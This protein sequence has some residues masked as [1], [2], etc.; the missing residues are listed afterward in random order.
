MVTYSN[1]RPFDDIKWKAPMYLRAQTGDF[2]PQPDVWLVWLYWRLEDRHSMER[3]AIAK[4]SDAVRGQDTPVQLTSVTKYCKQNYDGF[5]RGMG[6]GDLV[7][8][9]KKGEDNFWRVK[10]HTGQVM[11][12]SGWTVSSHNLATSKV[13]W[14]LFRDEEDYVIVTDPRYCVPKFD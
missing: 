7:F 13:T 1:T 9:K 2:V 4:R 3:V 5:T 14:L 12:R 6:W 11:S 8:V 10:T